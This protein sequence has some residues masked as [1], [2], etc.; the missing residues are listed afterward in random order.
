MG[1]ESENE[2]Y[3]FNRGLVYI[4]QVGR[5]INETYTLPVGKRSKYVNKANENTFVYRNADDRLLKVICRAY[6][7]GVAFRYELDNQESLTIR[8]ELTECNLS[9]GTHT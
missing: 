5:S 1:I 4:D 8:H 6:D 2:R 9:A 3:S 7:D